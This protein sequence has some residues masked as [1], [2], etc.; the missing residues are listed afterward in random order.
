MLYLPWWYHLNMSNLNSVRGV[1]NGRTARMITLAA[2]MV[3]WGGANGGRAQDAA[4]LRATALSPPP[5]VWK[6]EVTGNE[7]RVRLSGDTLD[8]LWINIPPGLARRGAYIRTECRRVGSKWIGTT[9]SYL[10]CPTE[11]GARNSSPKSCPLVTRIEF[12]T[13]TPARISGRA[14]TRK[15][16]DCEHCRILETAWA[17]FVWVPVDQAGKRLSGRRE[18]GEGLATR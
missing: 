1:K 11:E 17:D 15:R 10:P 8:A 14:Q 6:S 4:T 16:F 13:V 9:R 18:K 7:Y 2:V 12:D 5:A 3:G